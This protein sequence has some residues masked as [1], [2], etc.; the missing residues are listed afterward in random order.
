MA[1]APVRVLLVEDDADDYV[2]TRDHLAE[3]EGTRFELDWVATYDAALEAIGRNQHDVYLLDYRLGE[4]D[5]LGVAPRGRSPRL[6]GA[7]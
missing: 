5:G 3:V 2:F 6:T 4:R 7:V 1:D